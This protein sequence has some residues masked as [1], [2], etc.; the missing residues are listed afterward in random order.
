MYNVGERRV[1]LD[2]ITINQYLDQFRFYVKVELGLSSETAKA[3]LCDVKSFLDFMPDNQ[4]ELTAQL[5]DDFV[6]YLRAKKLR[7]STVHRKCMSIRA[8]YNCL[9]ATGKMANDVI[10][11][12]DPPGQGR[13]RPKALSSGDLRAL[14]VAA[15]GPNAK[16]NKAM[17]MLLGQSGLRASELCGINVKDVSF[18]Q[19]EI[20][21][22]GKGVQERIVPITKETADAIVEYLRTRNDHNEALFVQQS[23]DKRMTRSAVTSVI[24][25]MARKTGNHATAHTLRH[26]FATNMMNNG[27]ELEIVQRI[28][29]HKNLSTTEKYLAVSHKRL[30]AIYKKYHPC[31]M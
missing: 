9:I 1:M 23:G 28:L 12:I 21:V 19:H 18:S 11:M 4:K 31:A 10:D 22:C 5:V 29:G 24:A 26:T 2:T 13:A 14:I 27:A 16:R 20:K 17:A 15:K 3:Y 7:K 25:A 30:F 8:F 6:K